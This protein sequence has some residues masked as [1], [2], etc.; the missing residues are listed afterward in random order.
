ML[1]VVIH[2]HLLWFQISCEFN[3]HKHRVYVIDYC[4]SV[5]ETLFPLHNRNQ[6]IRQ[7]SKT[8]ETNPQNH[9]YFYFPTDSEHAFNFQ[10]FSCHSLG[11]RLF[12]WGFHCAAFS[13]LYL[14]QVLYY[15]FAFILFFHSV[16]FRRFYDR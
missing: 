11:S 5:H 2:L 7:N 12:H 1:I 6:N 8:H 15:I 9:K 10:R 4:W 16:S 13:K 3:K 14:N